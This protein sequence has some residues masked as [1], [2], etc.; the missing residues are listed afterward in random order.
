MGGI[1]V[2]VLLWISCWFLG[3]IATF[4]VLCVVVR[5]FCAS[6]GPVAV[7]GWIRA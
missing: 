3:L 5:F 6:V 7:S 2:L 4:G 1:V